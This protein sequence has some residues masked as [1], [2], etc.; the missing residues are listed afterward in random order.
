M[1]LEGTDTRWSDGTD[2]SVRGD[3][4]TQAQTVVPGGVKEAADG[5]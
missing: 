4:A 1:E 5:R 2:S 3:E